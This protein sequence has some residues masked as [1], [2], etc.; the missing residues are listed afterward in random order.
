MSK[1]FL[2]LGFWV[3]NGL[4][5]FIANQNFPANFVLGNALLS[6]IPAL[7]AAALMI[8]VIVTVAMVI[9][10]MLT[11]IV[12]GLESVQGHLAYFFITNFMAIWVT[13]RFAEYAGLGI[14]SFVYVAGLA[15]V[16]D[17]AQWL[18]WLVSGIKGSTTSESNNNNSK[19]SAEVE[20]SEADQE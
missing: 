11:K 7:V 16:A 19:P 4:L 10:M 14:S 6:P 18:V 5:L 3:V 9:K 20:E 13:A 12:P 8:T 2:I 17:L 1:I 15:V